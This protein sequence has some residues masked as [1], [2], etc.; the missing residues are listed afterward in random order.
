MAQRIDIKDV[1]QA[2]AD[3]TVDGVLEA[4]EGSQVEQQQLYDQLNTLSG[5][6]ESITKQNQIL[7]RINRLSM[8]RSTLFAT[9]EQMYQR[10]G[11]RVAT[12]RGVLADQITVAKVMEQQLV[13]AK[14]SLG[15]VVG[16]QDN[17]MRMVEVNTFYADKYRAQ[18]GLMQ[19]I[20]IVVVVFLV[21]VILMKRKLLP[22]RLGAVLL[23]GVFIIG[24]LVIGVRIFD[25]NSRSNMV[26]DE[27]SWDGSDPPAYSPDDSD[28]GREMPY[29]D[30]C[31][32]G[33]CCGEQWGT[34]FVPGY[35]P[36][37][38]SHCAPI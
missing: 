36:D 1:T 3:E 30:L 31:I 14:R 20:I 37:A 4:I 9:L 18:S 26:F 32:N 24:G 16:T 21:L 29:A 23:I 10:L 38:P 25:V 13:E 34:K 11:G 12:T 28:Q 6:D 17:K 8:I 7:D 33:L 22:G 2:Q 35:S 19:L 27:Y 5:D 15:Q